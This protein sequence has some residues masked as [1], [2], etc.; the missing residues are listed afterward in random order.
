[1]PD[2]DLLVLGAGPGGHAAALEGATRG[3]RVIV[4]EP[5]RVGG[6]CVQHTC[7]PT[8]A[9]LS[10]IAPFVTA[11]ELAI[12]GVVDI[13][14]TISLGRATARKDALV[15]VVARGAAL[16]LEAAGVEVIAGTGSLDGRDRVVVRHPDGS[17]EQLGAQAIVIATGARWEPARIDGVPDARV[18]TLD[19]INALEKAPR[20]AA[21]LGGGPAGTAFALEHAF[22]LAAT[23][24]AVSFV[25]EGDALVPGLDQDLDPVL[26]EALGA[27][28][29]TI[30]APG[31]HDAV[32]EAEVVAGPDTRRPHIDGL[33]L[34]GFGIERDPATGGVRV[35]GSART[36]TEGIYAV[37]DVTGDVMLS[38]AAAHAGRVA[39]VGATGGS[40]RLAFGSIPRVLHID[41]PV[42]WV[43][44]D[45]AGARREGY[46]PACSI[47]DL[48]RTPRGVVLGGRGGAMKLVTDR[49][50]GQV[51]GVHAVGPDAPE[52]V[53]L[54]AIALAAEL[55]VHDLAATVHWHPSGAET[56]GE[57]ARD[58]VRRIG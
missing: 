41:P 43:G 45:E 47:V 4:L 26:R 3:A 37:G 54:G 10:A 11:Q 39:A 33:A 5:D 25:P 36:S 22:L 53:A 51:L 55:T 17:T 2:C 31:D 23:G 30:T 32:L 19:A 6:Q 21:V 40:A 46:D 9:M 44:R 29:V 1:M 28:G 24:V 50:L 15:G 35:D 57:A 27:L 16:S 56:I 38:S 12:A 58:C 13:G 7:I 8:Q 49:E 34:D 18:V 48:G 20:T 14:D 52:I 42:G